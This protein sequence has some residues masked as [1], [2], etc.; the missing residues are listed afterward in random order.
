MEGGRG[1]GVTHMPAT[2]AN[3]ALHAHVLTR[4]LRDLFPMGREPV[5][6]VGDP[7]FKRNIKGVMDPIPDSSSDA[8]L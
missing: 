5:M 1:D 2:C 6:G 8:S 7:C 4:C 3:G